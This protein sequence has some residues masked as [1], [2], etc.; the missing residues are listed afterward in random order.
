VEDKRDK[1][2]FR[3]G[4]VLFVIA[5]QPEVRLEKRKTPASSVTRK[6]PQ[7]S[8]IDS[9]RESRKGARSTLVEP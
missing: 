2:I 9:K 8:Y 4:N 3:D 7:A 1:T 5:L 6:K